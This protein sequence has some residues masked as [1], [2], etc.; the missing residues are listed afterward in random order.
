MDTT[1]VNVDIEMTFAEA[2]AK[3]RFVREDDGI[4]LRDFWVHGQS[5]GRRYQNNLH[6]IDLRCLWTDRS[7]HTHSGLGYVNRVAH[8]CTEI[9]VEDNVTVYLT[10]L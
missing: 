8:Y 1:A 7:T 3:Y 5:F 10:D 9:P 6:G 4:G 2:D